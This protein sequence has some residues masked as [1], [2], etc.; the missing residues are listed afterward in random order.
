MV[1]ALQRGIRSMTRLILGGYGLIAV[2]IVLA[3]LFPKVGAKPD[4]VYFAYFPPQ[5]WLAL[6]LAA[7]AIILVIIVDVLSLV[8]SLLGHR[9][10]WSLLFLIFPVLI[11]LESVIFALGMHDYRSVQITKAQST[12][13]AFGTWASLLLTPVAALLFTRASQREGSITREGA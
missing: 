2:L 6:L 4:T 7:L 3:I 5:L 9:W 8:A 12:L 10:G 11:L 13:L 1:N